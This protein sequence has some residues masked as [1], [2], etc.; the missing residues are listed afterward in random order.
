MPSAAFHFPFVP[1]QLERRYRHSGLSRVIIAVT[2]KALF[3]DREH[4]RVQ[5]AIRLFDIVAVQGEFPG[6][7][8]R[9]VSKLAGFP[10][11]SSQRYLIRS[12]T[13]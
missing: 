5:T 10:P 13:G 3:P 8:V 11:C 7:F 12:A 1:L 6:K 4:A 2:G 9:S